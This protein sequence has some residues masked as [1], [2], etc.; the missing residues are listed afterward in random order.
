[1]WWEINHMVMLHLILSHFAPP[2]MDLEEEEKSESRRERKGTKIKRV[3]RVEWQTHT[4]RHTQSWE[5]ISW[6]H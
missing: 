4:C 1:M 5:L 6:N 2:T 3:F